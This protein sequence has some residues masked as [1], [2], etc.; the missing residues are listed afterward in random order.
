MADLKL[1][2]FLRDNDILSKVIPKRKGRGF[3]L[4]L[5][6][7]VGLDVREIRANLPP[8]QRRGDGRFD[9]IYDGRNNVYRLVGTI[10]VRSMS[11]L[12]KVWFSFGKR[13]MSLCRR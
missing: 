13:M 7:D 10:D 12:D 3:T 6:K 11:A 5:S 9:L 4:V 8:R 1:L 2:Q